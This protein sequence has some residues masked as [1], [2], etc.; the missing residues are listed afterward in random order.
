MIRRMK[1]LLFASLLLMSASAH[2]DE[3]RKLH[4]RGGRA[5]ALAAQL[6][7]LV[8]LPAATKRAAKLA[9]AKPCKAGGSD[10]LTIAAQKIVCHE[11]HVATG[12][13]SCEVTPAAGPARTITGRAAHELKATL[14]EAGVRPE[15]AAG[16]EIAAAEDVTCT[17]DMKALAECG[18]GGATCSMRG[19]GE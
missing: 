9:L 3:P 14:A 2:A 12:S 19:S 10:T 5:V 11:S 16:R 17:L 6:A 7:D 4:L 1:A 13:F 8:P 18:G 15:G